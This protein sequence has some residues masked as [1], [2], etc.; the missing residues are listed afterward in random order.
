LKFSFSTLGCP[1]WSLEQLIKNAVDYGYDG[2]ELRLLDGEVLDPISDAAKIRQAVARIRESGLDVCALDTSCRFNFSQREEPEH[3]ITDA[4]HWI[5]LA[6]ELQVGLLRIFGGSI[7]EQPQ[8]SIEQQNAWTI[9]A[10]REIARTA[11]QARVVVALETHDAFSSPHRVATVLQAVNSP[12]VKALWD[13]HHPY[14]TGASAEEVIKTL[15]GHFARLVHIKDARRKEADANSWQLVLMGEGEI[16]VREML[17][18]LR[19][20]GYDGYVSV[21]W[22]KKWHPEIEEPEVALPQHMNWLKQI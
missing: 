22:E 1:N 7:N 3:N 2:L 9:E 20:Y 11:E 15:A 5:A 12:Y 17:L 19:Q 21:E 14:K 13:S 8:P 18:G 10:L 6:Q 4:R 16:P